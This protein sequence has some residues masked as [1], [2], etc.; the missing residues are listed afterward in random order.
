MDSALA[1]EEEGGKQGWVESV[2]EGEEVAG[3]QPVFE[4]TSS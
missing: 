3:K 2:V 4:T 1:G